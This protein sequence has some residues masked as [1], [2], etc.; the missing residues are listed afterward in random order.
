M[1][2]Y[3]TR[4][5]RLKSIVSAAQYPTAQAAIDQN[6]GSSV[7]FPKGNYA[8]VV[9]S[10]DST[11][12]YGVGPGSI[13]I[14][15]STTG[16]GVK[17]YP[18][19]TTATSKY[20]NNC[21]I[22]NI[23]IYSSANK[24]AGAGVYALQCNGFRL[25]NVV[26][27][28]HPEGCLVSGGQLN[29]FNELTV[30]GSSSV[31]SVTP[32]SN[33]SA[34]RFTEAPI[35]GGLF[36]DCFTCEV[37]NLIIGGGRVLDKSIR[38]ESAD[39]LHFTNGYI[40]GAYSDEIYIQVA[41]AN[42][43][44]AGVTFNSIYVDG[45]SMTTAPTNRNGVNFPSSAVGTVHDVTFNNCKIGN[46]I[47]KGCVVGEGVGQLTFTGGTKIYNIDN[48]GI[49]FVGDNSFSQLIVTGCLLNECGEVTI[50]KGGISA[51]T[52]LSCTITDNE[53]TGIGNTGATAVL[54]SGTN[55]NG[56]ID[57]NTYAGCTTNLTNSATWSGRIRGI[58]V[59]YT[60]TRTGWTDVG[61]PTVTAKFIDK[62]TLCFFEIKVVPA[63]TVATAAG[64]SYVSLPVTAAGLSGTVTMTDSTTLIGVGTG[65]ID[66]TNSRAYVPAQ[67][68]T[69]DTLTIAGTYEVGP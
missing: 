11:L 28:N 12:L 7:W 62:G 41:T 44:I 2:Q 16:H 8:P 65:V 42:R 17:F 19:D 50:N 52:M 29:M 3:F 5:L 53:F 22:E 1:T 57:D 40:N 33:S 59:T 61:T 60:T 36:Q 64:T 68:A 63:T 27:N 10:S 18:N 20:L 38:I 30:F 9:V 6:P 25:N 67:V 13:I 45:V 54:L 46:Y 39:G 37:S 47:G 43:Y 48:W 23:Q 26:I 31:L 4:D 66:V 21:G 35:D 49:D 58:P 56:C 55:A 51:S 69:A 32:V 15:T 24:T 34:L 14:T